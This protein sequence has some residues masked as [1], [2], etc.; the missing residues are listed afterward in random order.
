VRIVGTYFSGL[1]KYY[2]ISMFEL[3]YFAWIF[4]VMARFVLIVK[5]ISEELDNI[6]FMVVL[7]ILPL[8]FL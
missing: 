1:I 6:P 4:Q 5:Y 8:T 3:S 7:E 2:N